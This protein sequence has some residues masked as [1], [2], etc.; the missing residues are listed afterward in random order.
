MSRVWKFD[1]V[2]KRLS[3]MPAT[4]EEGVISVTSK[5][6]PAIVVESMNV[7]HSFFGA[8]LFEQPNPLDEIDVAHSFI[9]GDLRQPFRAY[10]WP[11]EDLT[12]AHSFVSGELRT[13]QLSYTN[14]PAEDLNVAHSFVSGELKNVLITYAA[15]PSEDL[16]VTHSFVSGTLT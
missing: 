5:P 11:S 7:A 8:R 13:V 2:T 16:G 9:S 3:T 1:L 15:W 14:W 12:L 4:R 10:A 6:Y